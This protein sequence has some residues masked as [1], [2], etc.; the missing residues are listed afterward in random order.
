MTKPF[1]VK[2]YDVVS[3]KGKALWCSIKEPNYTFNAKGDYMTSLVCDPNDEAVK[4]FISKLEALRDTAYEETLETQGDKGKQNSKREVYNIDYDKDGNQTGNIIFKFKLSNIADREPGQ[5]KIAV[6]DAHKNQMLNIPLVGN[7]SI[8]RCVAFANPYY[9]A[10]TKEIGVSL[11]WKRMQIL[12]LV[13]FGGGSA[14]F[15]DEDGFVV[16]SDSN[17]ELDF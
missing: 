1:A 17:D 8:I 10:S 11:M 9:M 5:D 2:G 12:E 16:D 3:P 13:E 15:D 6:V 7:G 4:A 14:D